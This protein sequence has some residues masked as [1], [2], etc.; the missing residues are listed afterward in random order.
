MVVRGD[1]AHGRGGGRHGSGKW[2]SAWQAR[3]RWLASAIRVPR[4][5]SQSGR[6]CCPNLLCLHGRG[7]DT[8]A[9]ANQRCN[10][11]RN[12]RWLAR[13]VGRPS[14]KRRTLTAGG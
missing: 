5:M 7:V 6:G 4:R 2:Q 9:V 3:A 13:G 14:A 10:N 1:V 12:A 11:G 8:T